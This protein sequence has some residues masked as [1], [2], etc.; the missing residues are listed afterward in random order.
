MVGLTILSQIF[1]EDWL[2]RHVTGETAP[3]DFF[4]N[5]WATSERRSMHMMRVI[6][7]AEKIVNL[8][9]APGYRKVGRMIL[10]GEVEPGFTELQVAHILYLAK[11]PFRFV[12]PTRKRGLDYDF[13]MKFGEEVACGD[14]KCKMESTERSRDTIL[15]SLGKARGQLPSDRPGFIFVRLP[16]TWNPQGVDDS[17][18]K[19]L[20][21]IAAEFF[22]RGTRRVV[23][24]YFYFGLLLEFQQY[25]AEVMLGHQV[26]NLNHRFR[27]DVRWDVSYTHPVATNWASLTELSA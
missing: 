7:L 3:T 4:C 14:A 19:D 23:S 16:Q 9:D 1:G 18:I 17:H 27:K 24:L 10:K 13:D 22:R 26:M 6:T 15:D 2:S 11:V 21:E 8:Q 5:D 25:T 20:E 12:V